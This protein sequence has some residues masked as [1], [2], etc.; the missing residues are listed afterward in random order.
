MKRQSFLLTGAG[1]LLA[2]CAA[3]NTPAGV[4]TIPGTQPAGQ[5]AFGNADAVLL[6]SLLLI[7][8]DFVPAYFDR[9]DGQLL[10]IKLHLTL[11]SLLGIRFGGDGKT[12]FGLPDLRKHEPI[13]GLSYVIATRGIYPKRKTV[14]LDSPEIQPLLGQIS[15][16]AYLPHYVPP[17]G[18]AACD[19]QLRSIDKDHALYTLIGNKFG[20]DG[21]TTFALPDLRKHEL[22]KGL[23]YV[24]SMAG[25]YPDKG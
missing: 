2:G 11:F 17:H 6:G 16:V 9:C 1:A 24:I 21:E 10:L 19:G 15:C 8:Y 13:E 7:P 25:R 23:T 12:T 18:W 3:A 20:G 14:E 5:P 22:G 4:L